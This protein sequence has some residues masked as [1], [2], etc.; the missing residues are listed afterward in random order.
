MSRA[1]KT[2]ENLLD[3]RLTTTELIPF[4]GGYSVPTH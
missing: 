2:L 1:G 3:A 4:I